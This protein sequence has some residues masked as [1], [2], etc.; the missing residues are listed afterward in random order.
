[1]RFPTR[2]FQAYRLHSSALSTQYYVTAER[3][4]PL[5]FPPLTEEQTKTRKG[6]A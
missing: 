2:P 1:V 5:L 6:L 3:T 4:H